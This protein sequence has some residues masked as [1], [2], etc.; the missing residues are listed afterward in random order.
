VCQELAYHKNA[1][2]HAAASASD[3]HRIWLEATPRLPEEEAGRWRRPKSAPPES[4]HL[5]WQLRIAHLAC[6]K[7]AARQATNAEKVRLPPRGRHCSTGPIVAA[8]WWHVTTTRGSA[9]RSFVDAH[10]SERAD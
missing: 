3:D 8:R 6:N 1:A 9:P 5:E 10:F 4:P 2:L 7:E